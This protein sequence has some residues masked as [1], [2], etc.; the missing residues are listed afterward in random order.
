[1]EVF[2]RSHTEYLASAVVFGRE[3][4]L[5]DADVVADDEYPD[6]VLPDAGCWANSGSV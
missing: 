2:A 4:E 6:W 1:M 3:I 5:E